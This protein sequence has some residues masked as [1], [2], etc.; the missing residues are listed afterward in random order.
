MQ[1]AK[2][3]GGQ[4]R[5]VGVL[6]TETMQ[7]NAEG[8]TISNETITLIKCRARLADIYADV[9]E[10]LERLFGSA[11]VDK[12]MKVFADAFSTITGEL[13]G[14]TAESIDGRLLDSDFREM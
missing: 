6:N 9:A 11:A 8:V 4:S 3:A 13:S 5:L 1:T 7:K 10:V 12:E 14:F 2:E